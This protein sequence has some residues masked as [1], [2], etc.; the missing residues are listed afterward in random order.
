MIGA[1]RPRAPAAKAVAKAVAKVY[2]RQE[3]GEK[4]YGRR[5]PRVSGK[6]RLR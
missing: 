3:Y 1:L 2:V 6:D 5:F 4:R